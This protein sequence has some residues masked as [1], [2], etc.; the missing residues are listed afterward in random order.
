[1]GGINVTS[2][3]VIENIKGDI[4]HVLKTSE[5]DFDDFGEAYFSLVKKNAIKGWKKHL[6]MTLNLVVPFGE[7][8]FVIYDEIDNSFTTITLSP[9]NYKRLTIKPNLW[10]AFRG[11]GDNNILLNIASIEHDPKESINVDLGAI[12]YAW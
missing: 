1:M 8:Q 3:R 11:V 5:T 10:L 2:L 4:Y 6:R 7:I 9:E 12:K